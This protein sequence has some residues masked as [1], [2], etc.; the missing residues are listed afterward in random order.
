MDGVVIEYIYVGDKIVHPNDD[1][2]LN[3]TYYDFN[4][5][6]KFVKLYSGTSMLKQHLTDREFSL[7]MA[8][9][10]FVCYEDCCLKEGGHGNGA[11]LTTKD[12][13]E[14]LNMNYNTLKEIMLALKKKEVLGVFT[15]GGNKVIT[16]NPYIY[17][18]GNRVNKTVIAYFKK[19]K[20]ANI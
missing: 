1:H 17:T 9:A 10:D 11:P 14:K 8:L 20:W 16:I 3:H 15:T 19:S 5:E 18:R 13:A 12:L 7:A 2:P 6:K 4:K